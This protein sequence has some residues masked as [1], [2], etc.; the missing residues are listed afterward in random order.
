M[1]LV[2]HEREL[3]GS[4][5]DV[6]H[7]TRLFWKDHNRHE[8]HL[9]CRSI[10]SHPRS[11]AFARLPAMQHAP[12]IV[13]GSKGTAIPTK[14]H[15]LPPGIGI[16]TNHGRWAGTGKDEGALACDAWVSKNGEAWEIYPLAEALA[17]GR[18]IKMKR[19]WREKHKGGA[20][21]AKHEGTLFALPNWETAE[22]PYSY[23]AVESPTW[24]YGRIELS[25]NKNNGGE[26]VAELLPPLADDLI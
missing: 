6:F 9:R 10:F 8:L 22:K 14:L 21:G 23:F 20:L 1:R 26:A 7:H 15:T 11:S 4:R 25:R 2:L 19:Q 3:I 12:F 18:V 17:S 16:G 5:R 24:P 13:I